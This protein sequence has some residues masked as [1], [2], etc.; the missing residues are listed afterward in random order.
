MKIFNRY[1]NIR[2]NYKL[3]YNSK[4]INVLTYY[5][6]IIFYNN[7]LGIITIFYNIHILSKNSIQIRN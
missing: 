6:I 7:Y 1:I 3:I 2:F 4:I 5:I